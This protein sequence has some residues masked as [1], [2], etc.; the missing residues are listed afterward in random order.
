MRTGLGAITT[1]IPG[2]AIAADVVVG[3]SA[4]ATQ[5]IKTAGTYDGVPARRV[6]RPIRI[7]TAHEIKYLRI[8]DYGVGNVFSVA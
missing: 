7:G 6:G 2:I 4:V 5:D 1:V 3:A 8:V